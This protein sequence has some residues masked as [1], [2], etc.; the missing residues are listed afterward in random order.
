MAEA[1]TLIGEST[2]LQPAQ[3]YRRCDPTQFAFATTAE[4]EDYTEIL[5]QARARDAIEFGLGIDREGYNLF[6]LGPPGAGKQTLLR[7]LL[8]RQTAAV[9]APPDWCYVHNFD[10]PHQPRALRLPSGRGASLRDDMRRLVEELLASIPQAFDSDEYR[11]HREQIDAEFG[12]RQ[13]KAFG[14]LAETAGAQN[15]TLLRTP[16]GFSLAPVKKGEVLSSEEFAALGDDERK[17]ISEAIE[18]LQ[19]QLEQLMRDALR[20]RKEQRERI[21]Q[22]NRE[23]AQYTVGS[24]I[25]ELEQRYADLAEVGTYLAAVEKNLVENI[26]DFRR[27][28]EPQPPILGLAEAQAPTFRHYEVNLLL[29]RR[30]PDGAPVVFEDHPTYQNLVGRVEHIPQLGALITDFTLIKAGA[31]HRA[32]GGYLLLDA[33]KVLTQPYAW[34]GLKRALRTRRIR[35]ESLGQMYSLVST[36]S[37][38]PEPI[39]LDVRIV[40]FGERLWY[41]LLHAYDPDFAELF[42]VAVDFDDDV[43]RTPDNQQLIARLVATIGRRNALPPFDPSA[44]ARL[45]EQRARAADDSERLSTHMQALVDLMTQAAFA[46]RKAGAAVVAATHVDAA[47]EGERRRSGRLREKIQETILRGTVLIDTDGA[48]VGQVNG[49]SVFALGGQAFAT[50][51]RIT[52]NTRLG[53]GEIIDVQREVDLGGPIHSKGVLILASFLA[54][55]FSASRPHSL[56]ASLVFEQTYGAVEGD[57]ASAAELC[58]LMSSLAD[59]PI[60]QSFAVTGSVNQYGELQAIGAVNQKIE[61][62]FDICKARGLTGEHAVV[63]PE[64]NVKNLMLRDDVVAAAAAGEFHVHAVRTIDEAIE[65]LT[66]VAAGERTPLGEFPEGTVNQRVAARLAEYAQIRRSYAGAQV[67]ARLTV[68]SRKRRG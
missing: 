52:A 25:D 27:G 51:S 26:D 53:E 54:T 43:P 7:Q 12:E 22:L 30:E 29:E 40:F 62:F 36:I 24:L 38:E 50:P 10:A 2:R 15:V 32:N 13:Q 6:V 18:S 63:I 31:L 55:R 21:R 9:S 66:G 14:A 34:E 8:A 5:G 45:I 16:T 4:V 23:I 56:R 46:A 48:K 67:A 61:G 59:T 19:G 3:L 60:R 47:V 11:A 42:K 17:R 20:W 68:K 37:L 64:S 28:Q 41:Y 39:P 58:A 57:S 65:L 49:L 44:V 33:Q 35:I 1:F